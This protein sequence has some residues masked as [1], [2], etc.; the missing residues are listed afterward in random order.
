MTWTTANMVLL[1]TVHT[2]ASCVLSM[3][4]KHYLEEAK[5]ERRVVL[6][7]VHNH[8]TLQLDYHDARSLVR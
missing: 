1:V 2:N 4:F 5:F 6:G 3:D 7:A 8:L